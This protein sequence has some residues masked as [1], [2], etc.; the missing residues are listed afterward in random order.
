MPTRGSL[1]VV[2]LGIEVPGHVTQQTLACLET[3][4]EVLYLVSE[5]V[6]AEWLE[7]VRPDARSLAHLYELGRDRAEIYAAIVDAILERVRAGAAVCVA[8][9]GHP[10]VFVNPSH[11]AIARARD[12]G[13]AARM[14]PGI[15]ADACLFADL[16]VDP[17]DSGCQSYE[18]TDLLVYERSIDPTA[19]LIIWQAGAVG[20]VAFAPDRDNSGLRSL[21]E[22][23][24]RWYASDHP[25][26]VYEASS[27][28]VV[29]AATTTVQLSELATTEMWPMAT[30]Y[31]EPVPSR[32]TARQ[33]GATDE[34]ARRAD[35]AA[36]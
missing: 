4:G 21:V 18:A 1:T 29:A 22:Y 20:N 19:A 9:Y 33:D 11:D 17:A 13:F 3:A 8:F 28:A 15:S 14:L 2:G 34:T 25:V 32:R 10:G 27:Y 12:E 35:R 31:L 36:T 26:V 6:A 30:L 5:P 23:L 16:G 24:R 7:R